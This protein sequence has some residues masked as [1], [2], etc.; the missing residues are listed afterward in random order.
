MEELEAKAKLPG[1][2]KV[3]IEQKVAEIHRSLD[4]ITSVA[5]VYARAKPADKITIVRS[6]QRQ[7][8]LLC[9]VLSCRLV[10]SCDVSLLVMLTVAF[11]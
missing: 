6:L 11:T 10:M 7:G 5:D 3:A 2:D 8:T 9:L 4:A 1:A